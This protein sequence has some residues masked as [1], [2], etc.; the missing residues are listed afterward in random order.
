M[1]GRKPRTKAVP[2]LLA[3]LDAILAQGWDGPVFVVDDNFI[4]H[5]PRVREMLRALM[6]W[7]ERTGSR[8]TFTTEVSVDLARDAE[9]LDFMVRA[10]FKKVF[11]GLETP[12]RGALAECGKSQNLR[13][14]L[15][16]AVRT[17][18]NA[19]LEVMGGFIVGFDHD[20][21]DIFERQFRFIQD[22]GIA[23]AM[24]GLLTALPRTRL[25]ERLQREGRLIADSHGNNTLARL[26]FVPRLERGALE[27]GY[28]A[29]LRHLYEPAT[30]YRRLRVLLRNY[31]PGGPAPRLSR[32][33]LRAAAG[34]LWTLGVR[35][36]GRCQYWWTLLL[37]ASRGPRSFAVAVTQ[38]IYGYHFRKVAAELGPARP[39]SP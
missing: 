14:D 20:G 17:L 4:G 1:N 22:S 36:S 13:Q 7:R 21:P 8:M 32:M 33:D 24:V 27:S 3:E 38:A 18:Q 2:Q 16:S 35:R 29:L 31:R 23:S 5:K 15:G 19:G 12:D 10:G 6:D 30:F 34:C 37:A 25:W 11:V 39:I 28:G 9:L 26:N